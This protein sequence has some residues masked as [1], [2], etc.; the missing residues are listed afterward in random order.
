MLF[1]LDDWIYEPD[2]VKDLPSWTIL[3]TASFWVLEVDVDR[4]T[5]AVWALDQTWRPFWS[6]YMGYIEE[7]RPF[8]YHLLSILVKEDCDRLK[9]VLKCGEE[10]RVMRYQEHGA[11]LLLR[12]T[13]LISNRRVRRRLRDL[14]ELG[15]PAPSGETA[16]L[17][18]GEPWS[19]LLMAGAYRPELHG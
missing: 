13:S 15:G 7:T 12:A 4:G 16:P 1:Y 10:R 18:A 11:C 14:L 8:L 6:L 19:A 5:T 17:R 2:D 3:Q 9:V